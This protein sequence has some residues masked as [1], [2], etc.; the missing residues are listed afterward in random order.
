ME[1]TKLRHEIGRNLLG[2]FEI[3]LFMPLA[4][5]RFGNTR[6]EALRS[7]IVP[8]LL[9]PLTLIS[10]YFLTKPEG[11]PLFGVLNSL[12]LAVIGAMFYG[13]VYWIAKTVGRK[14][15]FYQFVIALNWL[16]VAATAIFL[17]L[18]WMMVTGTQTWAELAPFAGCLIAY[19]CAFTCFMA[20]YVLRI[21]WELS[22]FIVFIGVALNNNTLDL[23]Y[24]VG[25]KLL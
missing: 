19:I 21:T 13:S 6:E 17:P 10:F 9:L 4:R 2:V 14:E 22:G 15:Y 20:T 16:S 23:V 24:W 25:D 11:A 5:K 1:H 18:A 7:F 3:A 12:R 8:L